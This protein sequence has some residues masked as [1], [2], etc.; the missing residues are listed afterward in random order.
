MPRTMVNVIAA[1]A[2]IMVFPQMLFAQSK[3]TPT[4]PGTP[5]DPKWQG[6][7]RVNDGR[8]FVTDGGLVIDAAVAKLTTLPEREFP[9][10]LL[11]TY[12]SESHT[13]E[14]GLNEM[15]AVPGGKTYRAPNGIALNATYIDFLRRTLPAG[16]VRLRMSAAI[17]PIIIVVN[18]EMVGALMPVK[19]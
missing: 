19:Q 17:R 11:E 7:L 2:V 5:G 13:S 14:Y 3:I 4:A 9:S 18:S 12:F 6:I 8:T 10:K 16:S 15:T 1:A